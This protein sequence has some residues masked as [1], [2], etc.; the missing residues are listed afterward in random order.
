MP[1]IRAA[2]EHFR[3]FPSPLLRHLTV[4][5]F[6]RPAAMGIRLSLMAGYRPEAKILN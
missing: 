4:S 5:D 6:P 2:I 3:Q 1:T